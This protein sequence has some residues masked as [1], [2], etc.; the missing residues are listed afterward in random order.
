MWLAPST[1]LYAWARTRPG[2]S[3]SP[4]LH[5]WRLGQHL[6]VIGKYTY[7]T[8]Q[9]YDWDTTASARPDALDQAAARGAVKLCSKNRKRTTLPSNTPSDTTTDL[10]DAKTIIVSDK[11]E[12]QHMADTIILQTATI[13]YQASPRSI[14]KDIPIIDGSDLDTPFAP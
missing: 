13:K 8:L 2:K 11:A 12:E 1:Q 4:G 5:N 14:Q 7:K 3:S 9:S 10:D 6:V